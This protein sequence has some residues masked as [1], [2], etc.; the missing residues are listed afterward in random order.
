MQLDV[1]KANVALGNHDE[2]HA[3]R[4][5]LVQ[6]MAAYPSH[7]GLKTR[8]I[9]AA[10]GIYD[11]AM[12][13]DASSDLQAIAERGLIT[14]TGARPAYIW[15]VNEAHRPA[16]EALSALWHG[17]PPRWWNKVELGETPSCCPSLGP[18]WL[19][20]GAMAGPG[21]KYGYLRVA[22]KTV[23]AARFG[24]AA[25]VG[26]IG[27]D[28]HLDH[29]CRV[30]ACVN[31]AHLE[32]V[33]V[34]ENCRRGISPAA[35]CAQKTHCVHGHPFDAENT[36]IYNGKRSCI[37]CSRDQAT[38]RYLIRRSAPDITT[39]A[40]MERD[41][42]MCG[43]C[44]GGIDPAVRRPDFACGSIDHIVPLALGGLHSWENV[45]AAHLLCNVTKGGDPRRRLVRT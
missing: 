12:I 18:C 28:L 42:C 30:R 5:A 9:I 26:P 1:I 21:E 22:G 24:Y 20:T 23:K 27:D 15:T 17:L 16:I 11:S 43:I 4:V 2:V 10:A 36:A 8:E 41:G 19:W 35:L 32:P 14:K 6:W 37:Q 31:P 44:G 29:L 13:N 45:Q 3:R 33:T 25:V 38:A 40:V 34:S 7:N 39:A